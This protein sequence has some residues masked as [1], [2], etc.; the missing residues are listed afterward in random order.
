L[1]PDI[2][3]VGRDEAQK[4]L[5]VLTLAFSRDPVNRYFLPDPADY[6]EWYPRL[7]MGMGERGFD[8]G[9]AAAMADFSAAALWLPPGVAPD[10]ASLQSL[11]IPQTPERQAA[12]A[13]LRDEMQRYHP[14]KPHWYL[15]MIGV[16]PRRQGQGLGGALLRHTLA[17]V[18]ET[19]ADAYLESSNPVNVPLYARHGFEPLGV[20]EA[21]D[22]P[23]MTPMFRPGRG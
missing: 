21:L 14:Q 22:V 11:S 6:L 20:I 2:R 12:G 16:D 13:A 7:A 4:V 19:G 9:G 8:H 10:P 15:W 3:D 23:P 17:K 5:G 1:Q 18:D